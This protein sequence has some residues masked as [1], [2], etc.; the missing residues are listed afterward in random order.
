MGEPTLFV[1]LFMLVLVVGQSFT[2]ALAADG[3]DIIVSSVSSNLEKG[4][5]STVLIELLNNESGRSMDNELEAESSK[6]LGIMAQLISRD[7]RIKILSDRQVAG[8]L[9]PGQNRS[10]LFTAQPIKDAGTG[11][12]PLE[13]LVSYSNLTDIK[14]SESQDIIFVYGNATKTM[15]IEASVALGPNIVVEEVKGKTTPGKESELEIVIANRGDQ[16]AKNVKILLEA[17]SFFL[18]SAFDSVLGDIGPGGSALS[19]IRIMALENLSQGN[20]ILP[21]QIIYTVNDFIRK[22]DTAVLVEVS[23]QFW[24]DGFLMPALAVTLLAAG[25]VVAAK[26]YPR[27][28]KRRKR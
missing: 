13:L 15:P 7:E 4:R 16:P 21:G 2:P 26:M 18:I 19:K 24:P 6:A 5:P 8:S 1:F 23:N 28:K 3:P 10:L 27:S 12:Y 11:I 25:F 20:Y 9:A 22:E 17:K 14:M